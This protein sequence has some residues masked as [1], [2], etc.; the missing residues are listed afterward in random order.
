[1]TNIQIRN[2]PDEVAQ[3]LKARAKAQGLS[4]SEYLRR[5]LLERASRP[6]LADWLEQVARRPGVK[7]GWD[8]V[9]VVRELRD[10]DR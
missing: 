8:S 6:T 9:A 1:M 4:L 2:V 3:T 5:D 10:R 7:G